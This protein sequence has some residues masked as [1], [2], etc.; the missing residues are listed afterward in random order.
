MD[1]LHVEEL[2]FQYELDFFKYS[3]CRSI[4]NL[5][6]RI[7]D[8][9]MECGVSGIYSRQDVISTLSEM[10]SDREISVRHFQVEILS[11]TVVFAR[12]EAYMK[13]VNRLS[14]HSSIWVRTHNDWKIFYHQ[15]TALP[16]GLPGNDL[17]VRLAQHDEKK[18]RDNVKVVPRQPF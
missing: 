15:A 18:M 14:F 8:G 9:F 17:D 2:I 1:A 5:E 7:A 16:K 12:Y 10:I 13:D 4:D 3:F 11:D 6:N